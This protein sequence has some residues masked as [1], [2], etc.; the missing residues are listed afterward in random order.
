M[1]AQ[2]GVIA[3][4]T[5]IAFLGEVVTLR[6]ANE[7]ERFTVNG[8][9]QLTAKQSLCSGNKLRCDGVSS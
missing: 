4:K 5:G 6:C 8:V 1:D 7:S 9:G 3:S 2:T